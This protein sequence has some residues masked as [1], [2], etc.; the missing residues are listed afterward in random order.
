MDTVRV[1]LPHSDLKIVN[2]RQMTAR[3]F[4]I[5]KEGGDEVVSVLLKEERFR[6]R[7]CLLKIWVNKRFIRGFEDLSIDLFR[8][9][10]KYA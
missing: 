6:S 2:N 10:V 7:L 8:E 1:L 3:E 9:I 5:H 4:S